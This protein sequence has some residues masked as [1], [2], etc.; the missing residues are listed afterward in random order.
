MI[1]LRK[2]CYTTLE[3]SYIIHTLSNAMHICSRI[4]CIALMSWRSKV[5]EDYITDYRVSCLMQQEEL[6]G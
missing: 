1:N 2:E 6:T 5:T 4:P 3:K